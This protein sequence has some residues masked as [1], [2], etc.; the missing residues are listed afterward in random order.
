MMKYIL[1][2]LV[3]GVVAGYLNNDFGSPVVGGFISDYVFD[4]SLILL[5]FVM[6]FTFGLDKESLMKLRKAGLKILIIPFS[7]ASGSIAGGLVGG[8]VLGI[9]LF[10]SMAVSAGFGWYTLTRR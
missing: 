8:Y 5:L 7:I 4:F 2:T 10:G 1:V 3:L 9:N 6:G